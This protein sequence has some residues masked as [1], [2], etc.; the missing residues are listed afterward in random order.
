MTCYDY[1]YYMVLDYIFYSSNS[2]A[3]VG[4]LDILDQYQLDNCGGCPNADIPSNHLS[5]KA[6]YLV[7]Y[8]QVCIKYP[9]KIKPVFVID[10]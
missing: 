8:D 7:F 4:V 3:C 5:M 6:F 2:L 9:E 10:R 1:W